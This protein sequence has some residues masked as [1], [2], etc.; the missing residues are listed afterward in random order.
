MRCLLNSDLCEKK[1]FVPKIQSVE[2]KHCITG[3]PS[4]NCDNKNND[5]EDLNHDAN[6][7]YKNPGK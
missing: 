3:V 4:N 6:N 5:K 1:L 7:N 2:K